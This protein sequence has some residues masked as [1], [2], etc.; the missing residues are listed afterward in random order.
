MA[1]SIIYLSYVWLITAFNHTILV[2]LRQNPTYILNQKICK[3]YDTD[4]VF[5]YYLHM[6]KDKGLPLGF[7][8]RKYLDGFCH[9]LYPFSLSPTKKAAVSYSRSPE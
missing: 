5:F 1:D 3:R 2:L 6:Y 4:T 8:V 9:L 7:Q